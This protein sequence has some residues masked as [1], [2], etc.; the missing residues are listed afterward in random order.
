MRAIEAILSDTPENWT[1]EDYK[2]IAQ[3]QSNMGRQ[4]VKA[5]RDKLQNPVEDNPE[6][7]IVS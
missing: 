7:Q 4:K 3:A 1:D 5:L 6:E 2:V